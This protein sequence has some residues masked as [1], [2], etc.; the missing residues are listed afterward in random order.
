MLITF[1]SVLRFNSDAVASSSWLLQAGHLA[2]PVAN[3]GHLGEHH[4]V[5]VAALNGVV[6][7][8][9]GDAHQLSTTT[10]QPAAT[11]TLELNVETEYFGI[12]STSRVV[13]KIL[14]R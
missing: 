11:V 13:I 12:C 10:H 8:P 4:Q 5:P 2:D 6:L 3:A 14:G 9:G 7:H 1:A